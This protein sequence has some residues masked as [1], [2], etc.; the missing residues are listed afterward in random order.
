M[1]KKIM[2]VLAIL[3]IAATAYGNGIALNSPGT[4][5]L[6]MGGAFISIA[7][8]YSAP[9]WNPAGLQNSE[10]MQVS[11]FLTDVIPVVTYKFDTFG[12][13]AKSKINHYTAPNAAF[14]WNCKLNDK[15]RMGLSAIVPAG[16]G[17]EWDGNDLVALSGPQYFDP[18][19]TILNQYVGTTFDWESKIGIMNFSL[20]AAYKLGDNLNIGGAFHFVYGTMEMKRGADM[21]QNAAPTP[22]P[23]ED[24]VLDTQY[25]E[26]SSGT[27]F[28]AGFGLQYMPGDNVTFGAAMRTRMT[29]GFSGD[30]KFGTTEHGFNRDITW[31]LWIGVGFA[32]N[33]SEKLIISSEAQWTQWSTV[34][35]LEADYETVGIDSMTL[36]WKDAVQ[37]RFGGEYMATDE[38]ALRAGFYIDPAPGSNRTQQI[39]I[40]NANFVGYTFG[41][42]YN[43]NKLTF[44]ATFEYLK[45]TER[46]IS[47]GASMPGVGMPGTHGTNI[48]A[49]SIAV[50]YKF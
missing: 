43:I 28:G 48:L 29:V 31:P 1:M 34:D 2:S 18:G 32:F 7:D 3:I 46:N 26:E 10:G 40:P 25:S 37:I 42:G 21:L 15:L 24:G 38:L 23:G 16:L 17:V 44:D 12:I 49:P 35:Y 33:A 36:L 11:F 47:P 9:Y 45:G 22:T 50:T 6:A 41:F 5:A 14:L 27:G 39:L 30:A 13:D 19:Q 8:D 20:S 4:K